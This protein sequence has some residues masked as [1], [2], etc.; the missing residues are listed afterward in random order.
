VRSTWDYQSDPQNFLR[1]LEEINKSSA[2]L[3]NNISI[4]KWNMNKNYLY[5]LE[6]NG[7]RIVKTLWQKRFDSGNAEK[8]FE[9]FNVDEIIIKP[10]ISACAEN[11]FR[12]N[13]DNYSAE[14]NSL[15]SIFANRDFMVQP[16]MKSIIEEGE[17]SLLFFDGNYSHT[18]LKN[19]RKTIS[20]FRQNTVVFLPALSRVSACYFAQKIL[21]EK[22][23]L[24]RFMAELILSVRMMMILH[25]W[26]LS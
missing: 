2:H 14:L 21:S 18:N 25:L 13:K 16:F 4:L 1:V 19:Q 26:S 22:L 20:V 17:Y 3:E 6:K 10:N 7:V 9:H 12:L 24:L 5:D 8:Y 23:I 11:T 15:K